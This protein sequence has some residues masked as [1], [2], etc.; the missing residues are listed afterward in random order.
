MAG[1]VEKPLGEIAENLDSKRV[2]ITKSKRKVGDVP[3]YGASGIVDHVKDYLF[4]EPLLLV[5]EDGANLLARTYPIAFSISGKTWVN[6]HAHV[7]RFRDECTQRFVELY[8]NSISLEPFVSGMAQPKLNQKKLLGIP[9][10]LPPLEEQQRIVAVLDAVF[11][12]LTHARASIEANLQNARELFAV[13]IASEFVKSSAEPMRRVGDIAA[14]SLGKMLDKNKNKGTP[15]PYL[16]NIN[17]RWFSVDTSD[18]LEMRIKEDEIDKYSVL[19]GDLLIC[20]GGY[21]GR[22]SI[23]EHDDRIFF[24]KALHRVRFENEVHARLL[25]YFLF[26]SDKS[27]D[28]RNHFSGAG[29]QH[30]TGKSL[31]KFEMPFPSPEIA[32]QM[33]AKIEAMQRHSATL[34]RRYQQKLLDIDDL[35]QSLVQKAFAGQI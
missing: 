1:W 34:E 28:L 20:E 12:G 21:P 8:L 35:R 27:G 24:Q 14:H 10:P 16:R 29:I 6:N 4:D 9:V 13:T 11:E 15:R 2:P 19:K 33:V 25:M 5:S 7:L 32:L 26:M 30:F 22:A 3:Y 17:I 18:L 23:W 31:A